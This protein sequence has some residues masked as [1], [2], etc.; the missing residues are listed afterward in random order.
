MEKQNT[1]VNVPETLTLIISKLDSLKE[2]LSSIAHFSTESKMVEWLNVTELCEYLPSH[3][4]EQTVYSWTCSRKIPFHKKGRSIMFDKKE[5]DQWLQ[6][7]SH[8]KSQQEIEDEARSFIE[9]KK[10]NNIFR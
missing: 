1:Y 3:P 7:G 5:I 10:K 9:S 8:Y 6:S 2:Q 4:R